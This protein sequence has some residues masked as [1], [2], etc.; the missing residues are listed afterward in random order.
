M[1]LAEAHVAALNHLLKVDRV[2]YYDVF[3]VGTGNGNSVLEVIET[4][5]Q[6]NHMQVP[7]RF[8]PRRNGDVMAIWGNVDKSAEVLGWKA[9]RS[10]AEALKDAWNW[11]SRLPKP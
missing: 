1:D 9:K 5:D 6:V 2:P 7:R 11:Q 8:G 4:F 3:N 10:L